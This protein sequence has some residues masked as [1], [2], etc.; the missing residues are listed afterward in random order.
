MWRSNKTVKGEQ[1][2]RLSITPYTKLQ[3]Y[4]V[5]SLVF[6]LISLLSFCWFYLTNNSFIYNVDGLHQH[7]VALVYYR[8]YLRDII[9]GL[10]FEHSLVIPD[11]DFNI[12][13]GADVMGTMHYYVMGDPLALFAVFVPEKFMQYFYTGACILRMYLAGIAF[14]ELCF[15]TGK[16]NKIGVL[17]GAC[18]YCF[19]DWA[20]T[21]ATKHIYFLNPMIYFPMIIL[22]IEKIIR[23]EKPYLFIVFVTLAAASNFYFFYMIVIL[24]VIYSCVRVILL[25][26]KD[27]KKIL[28]TGLKIAAMSIIGVLMSGIIL[29]PVIMMIVGDSRFSTS[30]PFH[31][32]YPVAYYSK[33]PSLFLGESNNYF[34]LCIGL[35]APVIS[36]VFL[37]FAR[38]SK[39]DR[40]L[41]ILVILS[42]IMMIFPIFGRL[43][44]G[45]SYMSN[46][47]SWSFCLLCSYVLVSQWDSFKS[48]TRKEWLISILFASVYL[49]T[50]FL[51]EGS[52]TTESF[53]A[54]SLIFV[55]LFVI[56]E[57][58]MSSRYSVLKQWLLILIIMVNAFSL[59]YWKY[60]PAGVNGIERFVNNKD[61]E[62]TS[63]TEYDVIKKL[64][65]EPYVRVTGIGLEENHN[66]LNG[67]SGTQY[68]WTMSNPYVNNF[69]SELEMREPL[70]YRFRGYDDRS[71]VIALSSVNYYIINNETMKKDESKMFIPYG[72]SQI[73]VSSLSSKYLVYKNQNT[74]PLGYCYDTLI[75]GEEWRSYNPVQKQEAQLDAAYIEKDNDKLLNFNG[76]SKDYT[77]PYEIKYGKNISLTDE[78]LVVT[79]PNAS[80]VITPSG[81]LTGGEVYFEIS[82]LDYKPT[83]RYDLYKGK[84]NV[85]PKKKYGTKQWDALSSEKQYN[86]I[87]E[88]ILWNPFQNAIIKV[89]SNGSGSKSIEYFPSDAPFSS[90]RHDFIVNMGYRDDPVDQL[91]VKFKNR[92]VYRFDQMNLYFIAKDDFKE[93]LSRLNSNTLQNISLKTNTVSGTISVDSDKLLCMA[94]PYSK[95]WSVKVDGQVKDIECVNDRYIGVLISPGDHNVEFSYKTPYKMTGLIMSVAGIS[96]FVFICVLNKKRPEKTVV[97]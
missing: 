46:R 82:G 97:P 12:G 34:W 30:Q 60:T 4:I 53:L 6:V 49:V 81:D 3:Y 1:N 69:R 15:G 41:K 23:G 35:S 51:L 62:S 64:S 5:F 28:L 76:T 75:D 9:K 38:K 66:I 68:Y 40:L 74:L 70:F 2:L 52:R 83:P 11:W 45:M 44:N 63:K 43:M 90:G 95:G 61:F 25:Y 26:G 20:M 59:S 71:S 91:T 72:F 18:S 89:N 13:E 24:T 7:Y 96:L 67:L 42:I 85:D 36:S 78:G 77:I 87:R 54:I 8:R 55:S 93:K 94:I 22:G 57:I 29:L 88:K 56:G 92:G 33:L 80:I 86:I 14:S 37:L 48:L 19:G 21:A 84:D 17:A 50:C 16:E 31:L 27:I 47:W 65:D 10:F 39:K 79:S 58:A 32:L 73:D